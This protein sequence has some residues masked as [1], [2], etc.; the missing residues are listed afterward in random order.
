MKNFFFSAVAMIAFMGTS[1]ANDIAERQ[2]VITDA[3]EAAIIEISEAILGKPSD[4]ARKA[5]GVILRAADEYG[6]DISSDGKDFDSMME[7]YHLIYLDCYN[8]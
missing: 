2:L 5:R 7:M 8:N 6:L 3:N 4:C 1:M